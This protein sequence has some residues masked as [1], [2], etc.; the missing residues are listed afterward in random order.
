MP[1][2]STFFSDRFQL[3]ATAAAY[4]V[5]PSGACRSLASYSTAIA[6][7]TYNLDSMGDDFEILFFVEE[8]WFAFP[9]FIAAYGLFW[10]SL[11]AP[12]STLHMS[13][14]RDGLR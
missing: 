13:W 11:Y 1:G 6:G 14:S 3:A 5:A 10:I 2:D 7:V 9:G 8:T 4:L 12:L